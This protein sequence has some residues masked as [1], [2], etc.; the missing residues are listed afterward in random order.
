MTCRRLVLRWLCWPLVSVARHSTDVRRGILLNLIR[1][2][3]IRRTD[4]FTTLV[5]HTVSD[6]I[7]KHVID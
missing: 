1:S 6:K 4:G 5:M 7:K 2:G 3:L